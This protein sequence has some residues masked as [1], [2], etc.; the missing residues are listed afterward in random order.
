MGGVSELLDTYAL[1]DLEQLAKRAEVQVQVV[2]GQTEFFFKN[3][4][5]VV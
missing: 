1:V 2:V 3:F 5:L 4:N